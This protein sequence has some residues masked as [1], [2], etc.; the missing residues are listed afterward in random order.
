MPY[1]FLLLRPRLLLFLGF[2]ASSPRLSP[3]S[4]SDSSGLL[5]SLSSLEGRAKLRVQAC[6]RRAAD[7]RAI[8]GLAFSAARTDQ[9]GWDR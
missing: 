7:H 8:L 5:F 9:E 4:S 2:L 6:V 3:S 1:F